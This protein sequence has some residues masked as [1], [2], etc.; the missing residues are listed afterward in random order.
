V[1]FVS[2]NYSPGLTTDQINRLKVALIANAL[3]GNGDIQDPVEVALCALTARLTFQDVLVTPSAI[4]PPSPPPIDTIMTVVESDPE[5]FSCGSLGNC[6]APQG[7]IVAKVTVTNPDAVSATVNFIVDGRANIRIS[8][9]TNHV[10]N[11]SQTIAGH[12]AIT[13]FIYGWI[14]DT[15]DP[16]PVDPADGGIIISL[17]YSAGV[18]QI[19]VG[20]YYIG[21]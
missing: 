12:A 13:F 10:Y 17:V 14:G 18:H 19:A 20:W 1:Y 3:D 15:T 11:L 16:F 2:W 7:R 8:D 5:I 9:A 6:S 21:L 4:S